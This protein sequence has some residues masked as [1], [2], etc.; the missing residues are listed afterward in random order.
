MAFQIELYKFKT[1]I[2]FF[3][4]FERKKKNSLNEKY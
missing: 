1:G 3:M 2:Y 4:I